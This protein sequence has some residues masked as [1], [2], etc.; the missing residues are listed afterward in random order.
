[1]IAAAS[2]IIA[3][4]IESVL[5]HI[6]PCPSFISRK[7]FVK[8]VIGL[9]SNAKTALYSSFFVLNFLKRKNAAQKNTIRRGAIIIPME[10]IGT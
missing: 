6:C 8:K 5:D 9:K 10:K 4:M 2:G 1:M 7:R 3:F